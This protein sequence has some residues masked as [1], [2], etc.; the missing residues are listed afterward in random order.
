MRFIKAI[1]SKRAPPSW[2]AFLDVVCLKVSRF[3]TSEGES[4]NCSNMCIGRCCEGI[5][6]GYSS[7][8]EPLRIENDNGGNGFMD[9]LRGCC[10]CW[11]LGTR[12]PLGGASDEEDGMVKAIH[13]SPK[14]RLRLQ[15]QYNSARADRNNL[16]SSM[17][18]Y[19]PV[20]PGEA[21]F[22]KE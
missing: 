14:E 1:Q 8:M 15:A 13:K 10:C 5:S 21:S 16:S 19:L 9:V 12:T 3:C 22:S 18:V 17:V 4:A 6:S 7:D 2:V 20:R 11:T